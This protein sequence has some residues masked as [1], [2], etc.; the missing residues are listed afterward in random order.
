M[1]YQC[2]KPF[3]K[4]PI[5]AIV[6]VSYSTD[7]TIYVTY[8]GLTTITNYATFRLHFKEVE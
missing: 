6:D 7:M 5:G 4:I 8:N 1:K 3:R 2:M